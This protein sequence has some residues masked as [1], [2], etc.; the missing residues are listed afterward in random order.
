MASLFGDIHPSKAKLTLFRDGNCF[1]IA[2]AVS[3]YSLQQMMLRV[4]ADG[5]TGSSHNA[6]YDRRSSSFDIVFHGIW[7]KT[8]PIMRLRFHVS[9]WNLEVSKS[10]AAS[11]ECFLCHFSRYGSTW[12][13]N[14]IF[15]SKLTIL[16]PQHTCLFRMAKAV[17]STSKLVNSVTS[18]IVTLLDLTIWAFDSKCFP[19]ELGPCFDGWQR[20]WWQMIHMMPG[21]RVSSIPQCKETPHE[22]VCRE[23]FQ[24]LGRFVSTF[25]EAHQASNIICKVWL[26]KPRIKTG[27][28]LEEIIT[29]S[30]KEFKD[31]ES[32]IAVGIRKL[33]N[34]T[35]KSAKGNDTAQPTAGC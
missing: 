18:D 29:L 33:G 13:L 5:S 31:F 30:N 35:P 14:M 9:W 10:L 7:A 27:L 21:L 34:P 8:N 23:L 12:L 17:S 32:D 4:V 20:T 16:I 28:F 24:A 25:I 22:G 1:L 11:L 3:A 26:L 19:I 15:L 2:S 6:L